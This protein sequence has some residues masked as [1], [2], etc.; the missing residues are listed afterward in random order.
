MAIT[1]GIYVKANTKQNSM[2]PTPA[3]AFTTQDWLRPEIV[4]F[5]VN[6]TDGDRNLVVYFHE[7]IHWVWP[8]SKKNGFTS[9]QAQVFQDIMRLDPLWG[10]P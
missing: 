1:P 9:Q 2:F 8:T 5:T 6:V 7:Q 3:F 10:F 4:A